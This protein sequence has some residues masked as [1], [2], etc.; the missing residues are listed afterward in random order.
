MAV[1]DLPLL[2]VL[3]WNERVNHFQ[4]CLHTDQLFFCLHTDQLTIFNKY[5]T[6]QKKSEPLLFIYFVIPNIV[7]PCTLG[8]QTHKDRPL[9]SQHML[10]MGVTKTLAKIVLYMN[11]IGLMNEIFIHHKYK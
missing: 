2:P 9:W 8:I 1:K 10:M 3:L 5:Q 7:F 11:I 4:L 6:K